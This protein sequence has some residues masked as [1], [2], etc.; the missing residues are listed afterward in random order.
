MKYYSTENNTLLLNNLGQVLVHQVL[1]YSITV[2]QS[3]I[4]VL[5]PCLVSI[6]VLVLFCSSWKG[7]SES[8]L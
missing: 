4:I 8:G 2:L 6:T 5:L 3:S 7:L 1:Q